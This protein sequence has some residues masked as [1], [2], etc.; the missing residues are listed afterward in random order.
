MRDESSGSE[1]G[2]RAPEVREFRDWLVPCRHCDRSNL[3][4][5]HPDGKLWVNGEDIY[6]DDPAT[7]S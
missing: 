6:A 5:L 3:V 1:L 7:A 2:Q 4:S